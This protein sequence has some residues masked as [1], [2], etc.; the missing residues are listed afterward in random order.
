MKPS[1]IQLFGEPLPSYMALLALGFGLATWLGARWARRMDLD[2]NLVID[3]GLYSALMGLVG[4]RL[5]HVLFDG[6]FWDYVHLCTDPSQVRWKIT[7]AECQKIQG[8]WLE[9]ACIPQE[10][11]CFAWLAIWR[12][13]LTY[14]GGLIAS[15]VFAYFFLRREKAPFWRVAD[16]AG[17]TIPL[18]LFFGRMGCFLGGC[19]FGEVNKGPFGLSF[20]PWSPASE[21]QFRQGLLATPS[22]PSLPVHP[23]QLYEALGSW[24]IALVASVAVHPRKRFDGAVFLFFLSSYALLRFML[25]YWRDDDRGSL[26]LFSTSQWIS[27]AS[28]AL[29]LCIY[30]KLSRSL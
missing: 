3:L 19:C 6:Y 21:A 9:G 30:R 16:M 5:M 8:R 4:A 29:S 25:E 18:G 7:A 22:L 10:R 2:P 15:S 13:G 11:D 20:P 26:L 28:I 14:Y 27:L 1:L 12:G 24:F 17:M 23:T